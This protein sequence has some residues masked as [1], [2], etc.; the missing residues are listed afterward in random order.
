MMQIAILVA[1]LVPLA[2]AKDLLHVFHE[3]TATAGEG[4]THGVTWIDP[5][6]YIREMASHLYSVFYLALVAAGC[7]LTV[8]W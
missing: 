8:L 5:E 6:F 4:F 1:F 3:R 2:V 7:I